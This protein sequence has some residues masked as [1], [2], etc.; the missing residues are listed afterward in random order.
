MTNL[1]TSFFR[2]LIL[3]IQHI[4]TMNIYVAPLILANLLGSD[5]EQTAQL[6]Q[7]TFLA[8]GLATLIQVGIGIQL[9]VMQGPSFVPLG[10][11]AAVG[12]PFGLSVMLGSMI[13]GAVAITLLSYPL[14][15][16][17]KLMKSWI[18]PLVGGTITLVI[19]V[20][21]IPL[22]LNT[23]RGLPGGAISNFF[24]AGVTC[25]V[26][27]FL[28]RLQ[29]KSPQMQGVLQ[30]GSVILALLAG[31]ALMSLFGPLEFSP[32]SSTQW[33]SWP[34]WLP[35]GVPQFQLSSVLFIS[36]VYG[37][38]LVETIGTWYV[39]GTV[40]NRTI[41]ETRV[42]RGGWGEGLGCLVAALFGATPV[43][44][45]AANAGI[46][47]MTKNHSR[48][49]AVAVGIQLLAIGL[50]PKL[51]HFLAA[52]PSPA[53]LGVFLGACGA[54]AT[55]GYRLVQTFGWSTR[56]QVIVGVPVAL[57]VLTSVMPPTW[58]QALPSSL[59]PLFSSGISVGALATILLN[60][61]WR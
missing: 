58:I 48:L 27:T 4:L 10:A 19:G 38:I 25:L 30:S 52:I 26:L 60:R 34:R 36:F 16:I 32:D 12:K 7:M 29:L 57:S 24:V 45:Y 13:P 61:F 50:I 9:P 56:N 23:I 39:V 5:S 55:S 21:L 11:L 42:N 31:T 37:V 18:T 49:V 17:G 15:M 35:F 44:G 14:K 1:A 22:A 59:A 53:M 6:I 41:D 47:A 28:S 2:Y 8:S 33:I 3:G 51:I 43:T 46:L 40:M 20:S 54:I